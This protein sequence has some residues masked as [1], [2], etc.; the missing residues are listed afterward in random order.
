MQPAHFLLKLPQ[1][2]DDRNYPAGVQPRVLLVVF[3]DA[4]LH[5]TE[6][7]GFSAADVEAICAMPSSTNS[8]KLGPFTGG[9]G[10]SVGWERKHVPAALGALSETVCSEIVQPD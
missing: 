1:N 5:A 10:V 7:T 9:S 4:I 2:A 3:P 8:C 6:G